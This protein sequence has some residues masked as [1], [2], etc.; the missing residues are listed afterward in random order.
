MVDPFTAGVLSSLA[1]DGLKKILEPISVNSSIQKAARQTA[2]EYEGV[3]TEHLLIIVESVSEEIDEFKNEGKPLPPNLLANKLDRVVDPEMNINSEEVV[4]S[5]L[6]NIE[7]EISSNPGLW[8]QVQLQYLRRQEDEIEGMQQDIKKIKRNIQEAEE[9]RPSPDDLK[10]ENSFESMLNSFISNI[11]EHVLVLGSYEDDKKD[12]LERL[13]DELKKREYDASLSEELPE[14]Q[15]KSLEQNVATQ[16][17]LSSFCIIVDR[18]PSGHLVEYE[19]AKRLRVIT[20][21][22]APEDSRSTYMIGAEEIIDVNYIQT[23]EFRE[24]PIEVLDDA[25]KWAEQTLEERMNAYQQR[26]P[27]RG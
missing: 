21:V 14:E 11:D 3:R 1:Y 10:D 27:W 5:F 22:L 8:R 12:E 19:L 9:I 24:D 4:N 2:E 15:H 18:D 26:Y 16:M 7:R 25:T 17:Q 13:R 6:K 23:F 20:A